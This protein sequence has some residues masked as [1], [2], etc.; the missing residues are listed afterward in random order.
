VFLT[1]VRGGFLE[2]SEVTNADDRVLAIVPAA[3]KAVR[4]GRPKQAEPID[5]TCLPGIVVRNALQSEAFERVVLVLGYES[6]RVR[7]A[8]G[9]LARHDKLD[10]VLNEDYERGMSTSLRAGIDHALSRGCDAVAFLPGD[11]P[12]LDSGLI[13]TVLDRYRSSCSRL[14][15]VQT[16]GRP[17]HP[18]V[19][20]RDLFN[21]FRA[22]TGDTG[23]REI[24]RRNLGWAL[25]VTVDD[26]RAA[27]Q[28][29]IDTV[30]DLKIFLS[31][32]RRPD[33]S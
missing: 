25:G 20:R 23:G 9:A 14:C 16:N 3:G 6:K 11:M 22:I 18:I 31:H 26:P 1:S 8:L 21:E 29:D 24:I 33:H 28:L 19:V 5:N 30:E 13:A 10:I 12:L 7:N 27:S 4:F 17:G 15:Y 32:F 2:S